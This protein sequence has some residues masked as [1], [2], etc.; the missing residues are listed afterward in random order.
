M[1]NPISK[2]QQNFIKNYSSYNGAS[3]GAIGSMHN[4][5]TCMT[6]ATPIL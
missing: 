3:E 6:N 4:Y 5:D 2:D 1:F